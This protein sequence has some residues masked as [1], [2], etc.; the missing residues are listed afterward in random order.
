[1]T[2]SE[3]P[4]EN[5]DVLFDNQY[6]TAGYDDVRR[7]DGERARYYW[8]D[9]TNAVAVV[10]HDRPA[11]E[12]VM[13]EN[14]RPKL[15]AR[16]VELPGGGI[17]DEE[18]TAAAHRELREETGFRADRVEHLGSYR[19]AGWTRMTRHVCYATG[20]TS[21]ERALDDGEF[22][23]VC[24]RGVSEAVRA[25]KRGRETGWT[26]TPLLWAREEDLL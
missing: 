10:A 21:G 2:D 17:D 1:M 13:V 5:S 15:Q 25:A 8:V 20:L 7:P 22:L 23:T 9:A 3:W 11:D 26:L 4:V 24:R 14:Y 18:P 6:L 16:F 12:L 19:P